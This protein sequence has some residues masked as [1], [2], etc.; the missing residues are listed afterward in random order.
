MTEDYT[1]N[2]ASEFAA[3]ML[4]EI[5]QGNSPSLIKILE[6]SMNMLMQA[7]RKLHLSQNPSDKGNGLFSRKLGSSL[8]S[9][10]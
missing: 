1:K 9:L 3:E 4:N 10:Q 7:E 6:A 8:G 2:K 5:Q